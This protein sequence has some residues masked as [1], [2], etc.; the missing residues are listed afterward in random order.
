MANI[1]T[2]KPRKDKYQEDIENELFIN[3]LKDMVNEVTGKKR[4]IKL[5]QY[6]TFNLDANNTLILNILEV[7]GVSPQGNKIIKNPTCANMQTDY[8]AF[9]GWAICLKAWFKEIEKVRFSWDIP[10]SD[11]KNKHYNRFL[12]RVLRF[13]EAF[14]GWFLVDNKNCDEILQFKKEFHSLQN[15]AYSKEPEFKQKHGND[16]FGETAMEYLM[17]NEFGD[18]L[19]ELY[20]TDVIDRQFPIG[21]KKNG[22]Q[23]FTGGMSAIDLWGQTL[24]TLTV[25]ELK[26]GD[27]NKVGIISELFLYAC[28]MRDIIRGLIKAPDKCPKNTETNFYTSAGKIQSIN[29]EML[30]QSH[31]P[32]LECEDVFNLLNSMSFEIVPLKF[33][34]TKYKYDKLLNKLEFPNKK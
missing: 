34:S 33:S 24:E 17:A 19:K 9:E 2:I 14:S 4:N 27:N 21:I 7:E 8:A 29:A 10:A 3:P 25:I 15:N 26:Y 5:P 13:S 20:H 23:F 30:V 31:H 12:Y 28:A 18:K 22:K 32:L 6:I 16:G 11:R 1:T